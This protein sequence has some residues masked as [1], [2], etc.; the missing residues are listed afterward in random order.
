MGVDAFIATDED[1]AWNRKHLRSLDL[2][3]QSLVWSLPLSFVLQSFLTKL[4]ASTKL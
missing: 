2:F 1:E 3:V 4:S